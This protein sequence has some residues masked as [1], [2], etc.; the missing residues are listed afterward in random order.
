M[1]LRKEERKGI[2]YILKTFLLLRELLKREEL[3]ITE[4]NNALKAAKCFLHFKCD[5][6]YDALC[7]L[8]LELKK[9]PSME[10]LPRA[11]SAFNEN[12]NVKWTKSLK[13]TERSKRTNLELIVVIAAVLSGLTFLPEATRNVLFE[14][15]QSVGSAENIQVIM[16]FLLIIAVTYIMSLVGNY[17]LSPLEAKEFRPDSE[18]EY[19]Q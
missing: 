3:E 4:L 5:A 17:Y 8:A 9:F 2:V 11:L 13:E 15:M 18:V 1:Y 10:H 14:I 7:M 12:P 16:G 6:P 19:G